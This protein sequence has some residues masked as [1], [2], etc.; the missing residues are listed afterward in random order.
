MS[1]VITDRRIVSFVVVSE[2]LNAD[3][4]RRV[5]GAEPDITSAGTARF[6]LQAT[7]R[8]RAAGSGEVDLSSLI[9]DVISRVAPLRGALASLRADHDPEV[10]CKLEIVQYVGDD[11]YGPGFAIKAS[12]VALL[13]DLRAF[14]DVDQYYDG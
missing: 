4:L 10:T 8:L 12:H 7:W 6:P 9:E 5:I 2:R 14:V 1:A 3:E 13:A 11:P